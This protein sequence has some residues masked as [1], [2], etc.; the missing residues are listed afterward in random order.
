ML[1]TGLTLFRKKCYKTSLFLVNMSI[2]TNIIQKKNNQ[3]ILMPLL[4]GKISFIQLKDN[5]KYDWSIL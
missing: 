1:K 4:Q 3:I 5:W 2:G